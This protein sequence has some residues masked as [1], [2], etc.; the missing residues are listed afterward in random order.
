MKTTKF[1]IHLDR[2]PY[3]EMAY[4]LEKTVGTIQWDLRGV[5][6]DTAYM[7]VQIQDGSVQEAVETLAAFLKTTFEVRQGRLRFGTP[8]AIPSQVP[9]RLRPDD[10]DP[11]RHIRNLSN[12]LP[13]RRQEASAALRELGF[14]AEQELWEALDAESLETRTRSSEL[15][16]RL[17]AYP[18]SEELTPPE[19]KPGPRISVRTE[20]QPIGAVLAEIL[21]QGGREYSLIWNARVP[22][23][24]NRM[25]FSVQDI[26]QD[27]ALR[28]LLSQFQLACISL[29]ETTLV[30]GVWGADHPWSVRWT[31]ARQNLWMPATEARA[32]QPLLD[33][34]SSSD[35]VRR[36]KAE[37][38]LR[39][40][41]PRAA[42]DGLGFAARVLTGVPLARCQRLR[43]E[44]GEKENTWIPDIPSGAELQTLTPAQ[45]ARLAG[46]VAASDE[47]QT[48]D[49]ILR[50]AGFQADYRVAVEAALK[51]HGKGPKLSTL[52]QLVLRS[53]GLDFRLEG[54][55]LV[56]DSM[57]NIRAAVEK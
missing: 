20:N 53:R 5:E 22:V 32:I 23:P 47:A 16:K 28:L 57:A 45:R 15:L 44:I 26:V 40:L 18:R 9:L 41:P 33:D 37:R 30:T 10:A 38:E 2:Q 21:A 8:E 56:I 48:L 54:D 7:T 3:S 29:D 51:I 46:A 19:L 6:L 39:K 4:E 12:D 43:R 52:L 42:L 27:G 31:P 49:Q 11:V 25:S 24:E 35:P 55:A 1:S 13:A 34:L 36:E 14:G 17:Y 50:T